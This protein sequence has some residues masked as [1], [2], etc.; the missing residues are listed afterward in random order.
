MRA[1]ALKLMALWGW[2][3]ALLAVALG[4]VSALAMAPFNLAPVLLITFTALVWLLDGVDAQV[5]TRAA[6]FRAGLW[7][8]WCFGFGYF[9]AGLH[10]VTSAFLSMPIRSPGWCLAFWCCFRWRLARFGLSR[11][12]SPAHSGPRGLARLL[13]FAVFLTAAEWVRGHVFTGF[14]WNSLGL[15]AAGSEALFPDRGLCRRL[16]PRLFHCSDCLRA[17][18][19]RR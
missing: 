5:A 10:W 17:C 16:W 7:L 2:R 19:V 13:V 11:L 8:G 6:A 18:P 4:A 15:A 12:A 3:R 1:I 9:L 14:P